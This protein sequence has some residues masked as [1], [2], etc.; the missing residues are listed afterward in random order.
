MNIFKIGD[1]VKILRGG[2]DSDKIGEIRTVVNISESMTYL[3]GC[4]GGWA[5]GSDALE[6]IESKSNIMKSIK[7]IYRNLTRKEPEKSFVATGVTDSNDQ[8]TADGKDLLLSFLLEQNKDAFN[9]EVV[10]PILEAQKAEK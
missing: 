5:N 3:E 9:A 10:Q 2:V 7:E 4:I 8:L 1:R 6:L